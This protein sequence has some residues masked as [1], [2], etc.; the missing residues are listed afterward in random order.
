MWISK[1]FTDLHSTLENHEGKKIQEE[2]SQHV[3]VNYG[4]LKRGQGE[5]ILRC[6]QRDLPNGLWW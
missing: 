3:I 1:I 4:R 2:I 5:G 6:H